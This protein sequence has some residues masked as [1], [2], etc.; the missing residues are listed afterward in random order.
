MEARSVNKSPHP[1]ALTSMASYSAMA[2]IRRASPSSK[3]QDFG[4]RGEPCYHGSERADGQGVCLFES[5]CSRLF[6]QRVCC[7][8]IVSDDSV[9]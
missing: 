4:R 6:Y 9:G 3:R 7:S 5:L 2:K 8:S 1:S